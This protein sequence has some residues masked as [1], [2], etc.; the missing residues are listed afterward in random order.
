MYIWNWREVEIYTA[1][2][3]YNR[4]MTESQVCIIRPQWRSPHFYLK[5]NLYFQGPLR[6]KYL[7]NK[8]LQLYIP[9]N[10]YFLNDF[11]SFFCKFFSSHFW[12]I[13]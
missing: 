11:Y 6:L 12:E 8:V 5:T 7:E 2:S 9:H 10:Y 3:V 1:D 13:R 4:L